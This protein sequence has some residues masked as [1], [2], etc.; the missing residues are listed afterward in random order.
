MAFNVNGTR[1]GR[2]AVFENFSVSKADFW[3]CKMNVSIS[4]A[5]TSVPSLSGSARAGSL[6]R[7]VLRFL[8]SSSSLVFFHHRLWQIEIWR[9]ADLLFI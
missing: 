9:G 5:S 4:L 1:L 8:L 6:S 3:G 7:Y 2:A